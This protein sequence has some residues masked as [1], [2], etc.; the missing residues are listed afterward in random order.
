MAQNKTRFANWKRGINKDTPRNQIRD[1]EAVDLNNV[2]YRSGD[3]E[4]R[5]GYTTPY[6]DTGAALAINEVVDYVSI[7][8]V[9]TLLRGHPDGIDYLSTLT[10]TNRLNLGTTRAVTDKWF[11]AEGDGASYACN[12]LDSVYQSTDPTSVSYTAVTWDTSTVGSLTGTTI[13]R[14]NIPLFMN[15]RLF[16]CNTTDGTDGSLPYRVRYTN[17]RDYNRTEGSTGFY[18]FN[19]TQTGIEAATT[20]LNNS[21]VLF[22][23]DVV[24]IV[25]NTGNPVLS[26]ILKFEPGIL[27]PKAFCHLPNG[28]I[29]YVSKYGFHL[30]AG[31]LPEDVGR[32]RVREWFF[33][34]LD[35]AYAKNVYCWADI[36]N[37]EVHTMFPT[38][39]NEP[40]K[41]L[42]YNWSTGNFYT[43]DIDGWCGF[44]RDRYQ[45][46]T[47]RYLGSASGIVK[48]AGGATDGVTAI[49][50]TL[51]TKAYD[52]ADL[53]NIS[54]PMDATTAMN[55]PNYIQA[56]RIYSDARPAATVFYLGSADYGTEAPTYTNS[57]ALTDTNG[58]Q[59]V[60]NIDPTTTAY[61]SIKATGFDNISEI[62]TEWS[63]AGDL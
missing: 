3:W 13:T 12:G 55:T 37:A 10:W 53:M 61:L 31:G 1:D 40:D 47:N 17:V 39:N 50:A 41:D 24:G 16:L 46:A 14:A 58:Y 48:L 45:S 34:Q 60:A 23:E 62:T 21:L 6:T 19:D 44:Y 11:F 29:W 35:R 4:K 32:N 9:S 25:Q 8:G 63:E 42:I 33:S 43:W 5:P 51:E 38:G 27:A 57:A 59:P 54:R 2:I 56:N 22:K 52:H 28:A 49:S 26:P 30:F 7:G 18:D 15:S 20:L 36:E